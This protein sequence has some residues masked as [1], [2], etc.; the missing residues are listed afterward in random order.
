M[1]HTI[2][3]T[4]AET[5]KTMKFIDFKEPGGPDVLFCNQGAIPSIGD[6]EVL[7]RVR[8]AGVN[9]ADITQRKG[10]YPPPAGA[11]PVL[12]LEVSGEI[13]ETGSHVSA[14]KPGDRVC[15]LVPGGG[16]AEWVKTKP[17]HCLPIPK[18]LGFIES[19]A[20]PETCF[21]VWS[22]LI[23]RASLKA[24]ET[25]LVHGGSGG[26]GTTAIQIARALGVKVFVTAGT[27]EKCQACE[28]LGAEAINYQQQ[29]FVE[30]IKHYTGGAGVNVIL[31]ILGGEYINRNL[32]ALA[33]EGRLVSIAFS[34]G[35]KATVS[36]A[37]IMAKR[38]IWTGSTLRPQSDR[39]KD[40]IAEALQH[41]IWPLI[42][43]G[44][45]KPVIFKT[46]PLE[47]AAKAHQL[48]ESSA[49]IGKIIL[50]TD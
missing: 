43:K 1:P 5:V 35:H 19:A 2:F 16:Y 9:G 29:D 22:N 44:K 7:I 33:L 37:P 50:T 45:I 27:N 32:K 26:I 12:G 36:I 31:D 25:L 18:G 6:D 21:T 28:E 10:L 14:W 17:G 39:V 42:E 40:S 24:G 3:D 47:Q 11:S 48:L 23:D 15:A 41:T 8:A 30:A 4:P 20:L 46:F 38:L 13:T 34:Q 49:H